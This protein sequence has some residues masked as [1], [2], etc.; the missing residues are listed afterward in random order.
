MF[1]SSV[2]VICIVVESLINYYKARHIIVYSWNSLT[3]IMAHVYNMAL[4]VP[5]TVHM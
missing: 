4:V 2:A 5:L 3:R 1:L